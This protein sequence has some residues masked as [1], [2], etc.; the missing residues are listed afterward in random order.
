LVLVG[1]EAARL[2]GWNLAVLGALGVVVGAVSH[3]AQA[4]Q[5][6]REREEDRDDDAGPGEAGW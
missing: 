5:R 6:R 4:R 3:A 2:L 1:N